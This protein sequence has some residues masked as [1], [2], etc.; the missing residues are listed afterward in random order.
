MPPAAKLH[1]LL[2]AA[3]VGDVK[4]IEANLGSKP[5]SIVDAVRAG[6][7]SRNNLTFASF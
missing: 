2:A 4:A 5:T 3:T 6:P 1:P 7:P